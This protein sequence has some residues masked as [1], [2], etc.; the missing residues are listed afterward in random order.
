MPSWLGM[1]LLREALGTNTPNPLLTEVSPRPLVPVGK[2]DPPGAGTPVSYSLSH[3]LTLHQAPDPGFPFHK[4]PKKGRNTLN[5]PD[6]SGSG[7]RT[8]AG[9][10]WRVWVAGGWGGRGRVGR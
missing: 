6:R 9:G 7:T 3:A 8:K 5:K 10:M 1:G 4:L 2:G